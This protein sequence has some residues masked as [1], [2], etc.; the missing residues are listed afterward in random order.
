MIS[1]EVHYMTSREPAK[2]YPVREGVSLQIKKIQTQKQDQK[3][4]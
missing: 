3:F 1:I 4:N 2:P